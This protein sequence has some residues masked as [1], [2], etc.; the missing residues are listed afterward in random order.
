MINGEQGVADRRLKVRNCVKFTGEGKKPMRNGARK[1]SVN[2]RKGEEE[3]M[4]EMR[5]KGEEEKR[6]VNVKEH[7]RKEDIEKKFCNAQREKGGRE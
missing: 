4:N 1:K 2:R 6:N 3:K 7:G 5:E